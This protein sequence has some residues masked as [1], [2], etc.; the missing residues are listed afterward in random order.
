MLV[1]EPLHD[2]MNHINN[3]FLELPHHSKDKSELKDLIEASFNGK[4]SQRGVDQQSSLIKVYLFCK[5]NF[6][7]S[8]VTCILFTLCEIRRVLYQQEDGRTN[9]SI[10][11]LY[12]QTFLHAIL[13]KRNLKITSMTER[14]FFGKYYHA[15]VTHACDQYRILDGRTSNTESDERTFSFAKNISDDTSN[16]P[17]NVISNIFIRAQVRESFLGS[18]NII[19]EEAQISKMYEPIKLKLEN[20]CITFEIIDKYPWEYQALLEKIADYLEDGLFWIEVENSVLFNDITPVDSDMKIHHFRRYTVCDE[21]Q[22]VAICWQNCLKNFD[23]LI[24]AFKIKVEDVECNL[25]IVY[26]RTL[27]HYNSVIT[28]ESIH[29]T[30]DT[31]EITKDMFDETESSL[32]IT[33]DN[34]TGNSMLKPLVYMKLQ[35]THQSSSSNIDDSCSISTHF[36]T[37]TPN[38]KGGIKQIPLDIDFTIAEVEDDKDDDNIQVIIPATINDVHTEIKTDED[39]NGYSKP[40]SILV[41]IL[42]DSELVITFNKSKKKYEMYTH[43]KH[44]FDEYNIITAKLEVKLNNKYDSLNSQAAKACKMLKSALF[45]RHFS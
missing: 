34:Q 28:V 9:E 2:I 3:L 42:G 41:K 12:L 37:S 5:T 14:K 35:D 40:S 4:D 39:D 38:L 6:P 13:I 23:K 36:I 27:K 20:L 17:D 16:H 29:N 21:L 24:P 43:E 1:N 25:S 45:V 7:E 30:V 8:P 44:Y 10:L 22:Y 33:E 31:G 19:R 32:M 11:H 26:P 18:N 15:I